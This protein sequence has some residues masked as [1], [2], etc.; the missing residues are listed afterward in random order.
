MTVPTII[1]MEQHGN[2]VAAVVTTNV[3]KFEARFQ[4]YVRGLDS[5]QS[6]ALAREDVFTN[7]S[8][9][10]AMFN[11]WRAESALLRAVGD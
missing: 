8:A 1:R 3:P 5:P 9:A 6:L 10:I 2:N 7:D 11:A 4:L